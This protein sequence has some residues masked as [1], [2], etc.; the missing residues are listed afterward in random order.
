MGDAAAVVVGAK[1][2]FLMRRGSRKTVVASWRGI[3]P[4]S[5]EWGE[6]LGSSPAVEVTE[7]C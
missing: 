2:P 7:L 5:D 1:V 6:S 4:R 3:R